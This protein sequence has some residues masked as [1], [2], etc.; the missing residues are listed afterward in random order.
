[1]GRF[2]KRFGGAG[3]S[4]SIT[5]DQSQAANDIGV[6]SGGAGNSQAAVEAATDV[7]EGIQNVKGKQKV[8]AAQM[9][10]QQQRKEQ[11]EFLGMFDLSLE[12]ETYV[13]PQ[14]TR[15]AVSETGKK[16]KAK[17]KAKAGKK[18]PA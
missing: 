8:N 2:A 4:G 12:G 16:D 1:M 13:E 6:A 15:K 7:L 9:D 5:P 11:D 3:R 17:P 18:G 14:S 10:T